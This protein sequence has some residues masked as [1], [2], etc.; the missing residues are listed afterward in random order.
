MI[1]PVTAGT[2]TVAYVGGST[3]A[4][5]DLSE[6]VTS[7][8]PIFIAAVVGL[9]FILLMIM[10]RSILVPVKAALMN[11]LSIGA[12]YGFV[13]AVFQWGWGASLFGIDKPIPINPFVPMM[14]FAILFGLSMDYEVFL[15]SRIR[16]EWVN[17]GDSRASVVRGLASTAKV[18]TSAALIMICV[19]LSFVS[20]VDPLVKI[21]GVGLAVAVFLDATLVRMVLVPSTM[22]LLGNGNWW[23]PRW[24]DRI[25]P[26]LDIEGN[27]FEVVALARPVGIDGGTLT[28]PLGID[29]AVGTTVDTEMVDLTAA[30]ISDDDDPDASRAHELV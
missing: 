8:L 23:L 14:M 29:G 24:L 11:L 22:A 2:S 9:S 19:F 26:H 20:N 5:I 27:D 3:A 25:L 12:A 6:K 18:I 7:R 28:E 1:P 4:V 10:F 16:E 21:F 17:S 13:V 15:L 30:H